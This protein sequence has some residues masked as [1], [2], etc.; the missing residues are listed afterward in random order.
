MYYCT[1]YAR[2]LILIWD[3]GLVKSGMTHSLMLETNF[4]S[5]ENGMIHS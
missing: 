1:P 2:M 4:G 5:V 3:F